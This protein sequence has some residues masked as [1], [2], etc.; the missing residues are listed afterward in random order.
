M[1]STAMIEGTLVVL[2][3]FNSYDCFEREFLGCLDSFE[4]VDNFLR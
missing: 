2:T 3:I 1:V 4:I